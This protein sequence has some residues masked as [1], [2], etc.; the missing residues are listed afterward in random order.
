[1]LEK[2]R[3]ISELL[4]GTFTY[5]NARLAEHYGLPAPAGAGFSRVDLSGTAR[6]GF[7]T[8]ASFLTITSNP[9]RT[10]PVKRGKWVLDQLLCSPPPPPPPGVDTSLIDDGATIS[11]RARLEQHRGLRGGKGADLCGWARLL[12]QRHASSEQRAEGDQRLE[13]RA[14]R[15]VRQCG[16]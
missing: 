4:T 7:L 2:G 16:Q 15:L 6:I 11:M 14:A 5:V 13:Q 9:T 3:P 8:Q 10:S 1:L 12:E